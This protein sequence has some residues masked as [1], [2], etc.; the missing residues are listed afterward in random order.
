MYLK[1]IDSPL[2]HFQSYQPVSQDLLREIVTMIIKSGV[3]GRYL[4]MSGAKFPIN[5]STSLVNRGSKLVFWDIV[6]PSLKFEGLNALNQ[7]NSPKAK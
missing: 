6:S 2:C 7:S 5:F 3:I 4:E 1:E